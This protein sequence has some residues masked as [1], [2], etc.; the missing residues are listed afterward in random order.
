MSDDVAAA[1]APC[2]DPAGRQALC[3]SGCGAPADV[4][5]NRGRWWCS[6]CF[7]DPSATA[8][9]SAEEGDE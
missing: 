8:A 7:F 6:E 1:G 9:S 2:V 5:D 3:A 4:D